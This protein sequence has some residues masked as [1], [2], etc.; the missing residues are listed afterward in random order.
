MILERA[1]VD[2]FATVGHSVLIASSAQQT[3]VCCFRTKISTVRRAML[4]RTSFRRCWRVCFQPLHWN[5]KQ[6]SM[7]SRGSSS[8]KRV[9]WYWEGEGHTG[10]FHPKTSSCRIDRSVDSNSINSA[11]EFCNLVFFCFSETKMASSSTPAVSSSD[12]PTMTS[13]LQK[14]LRRSANK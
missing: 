1:N 13:Q 3:A 8:K 2:I 5:N 11:A 4:N 12:S 14:H 10:E 6:A 9:L 7:S